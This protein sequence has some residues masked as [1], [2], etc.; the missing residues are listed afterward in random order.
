MYLPA[1]YVWYVELKISWLYN[2][3]FIRK[4]LSAET[5]IIQKLVIWNVLQINR[6]LLTD[7]RSLTGQVLELRIIGGAGVIGFLSTKSLT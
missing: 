4:Y 7:I 1:W 5:R 3:E 6:M 2:I